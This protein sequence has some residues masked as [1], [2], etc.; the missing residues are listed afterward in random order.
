MYYTKH[1]KKKRGRPGIY[2]ITSNNGLYVHLPAVDDGT[3]TNRKIS[4]PV[5]SDDHPPPVPSSAR[6]TKPLGHHPFHENKKRTPVPPLKPKLP[7]PIQGENYEVPWDML[8]KQ[9]KEND[10]REE[11]EEDLAG[12]WYESVG[13]DDLE[14][15]NKNPPPIWRSSQDIRS[16]P[17]PLPSSRGMEKSHLSQSL[18]LLKSTLHPGPLPNKSAKPSERKNYEPKLP[19]FNRVKKSFHSLRPKAEIPEDSQDSGSVSRSP[20]RHSHPVSKPLPP[21]KPK[22]SKL[23][24]GAAEVGACL[25]HD[26]K[27]NQKLQE[28][29]QEVYGGADI[30]ISYGSPTNEEDVIK[31]VPQG[32]YEEITFSSK[33]SPSCLHPQR[34]VKNVEDPP[35]VAMIENEEGYID[36]QQAQDYLSFESSADRQRSRSPVDLNQLLAEPPISPRNDT[37][38]PPLPPRGPTSRPKLKKPLPRGQPTRKHSPPLTSPPPPLP[39]RNLINPAAQTQVKSDDNPPVP[40]RQ[41]KQAAVEEDEDEDTPPPVPRRHPQASGKHTPENKKTQ[42][43]KRV[44]SPEDIDKNPLP[45]PPRKYSPIEDDSSPSLSPPV[46]PPRASLSPVP[47]EDAPPVPHRLMTQPTRQ[48]HSHNSSSPPPVPTRR[49]SAD[50]AMESHGLPAP[51]QPTKAP[52]NAFIARSKSFEPEIGSHHQTPKKPPCPP[53]KP[54]P[55]PSR[56]SDIFETVTFGPTPTTG[57]I[58]NTDDAHSHPKPNRQLNGHTTKSKPPPPTVPKKP[59]AVVPRNNRINRNSPCSSP[60]HAYSAAPGKPIIKPKPLPHPKPHKT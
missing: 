7:P 5:F 37:P 31:D 14:E 25:K 32:N 1:K 51:E 42:G 33:E 59:P 24:P 16:S 47:H 6:P 3:Q 13:A 35:T 4:S 19:M 2:L 43:L 34:P 36:A 60:D 53:P 22:P 12:G 27:F 9:R 45:L 57:H 46:P 54:S 56:D 55:K 26:P 30:R 39:S 29:K 41:L 8:H 48:D 52:H 23:L 40:R 15:M 17:P 18:D 11:E 38:S 20:Q 28:R 49:V 21:V 44:L 50:S 10:W 58:N